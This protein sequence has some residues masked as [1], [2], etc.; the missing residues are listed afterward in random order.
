M[1]YISYLKRYLHKQKC[2]EE[3]K[4]PSSLFRDRNIINIIRWYMY[5][6]SNSKEAGAF[7]KP[8]WALQGEPL[9]QFWYPTFQFTTY[10]DTLIKQMVL[11]YQKWS[12]N[13]NTFLPSN[14]LSWL[15]LFFL[16][17][18]LTCYIHLSTCLYSINNI[19]SGKKAS[20]SICFLSISG[21]ITSA[22]CFVF[23][24]FHM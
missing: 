17:Y 24:S 6:T 4:H 19:P 18:T 9:S 12:T 2:M 15:S 7:N 20:S 1:P 13:A 10:G 8:F 21:S 14:W 3:F 23:W 16:K 5:N 22:D 11:H